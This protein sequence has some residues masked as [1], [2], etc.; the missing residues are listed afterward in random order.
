MPISPNGALG[1]RNVLARR[2]LRL[3]V[4]PGESRRA[5]SIEPRGGGR[6]RRGG[7]RRG[8]R[9]GAPAARPVL[10]GH[11][12]GD[13]SAQGRARPAASD[14]AQHRAR[15]ARPGATLLYLPYDARRRRVAADRPARRPADR[16]ARHPVGGAR[17]LRPDR[18]LD[19]RI[20]SRRDRRARRVDRLRATFRR[21]AGIIGSAQWSPTLHGRCRRSPVVTAIGPG[22]VVSPALLEMAVGDSTIRTGRLP[23]S[24]L[25]REWRE[26]GVLR[27]ARRTT[28][29]I[30]NRWRPRLRRGANARMPLPSGEDVVAWTCP[31]RLRI[32]DAGR[33]RGSRSDHP[34]RQL[35]GHR[36]HAGPVQP[37]DLAADQRG[38]DPDAADAESA[39]GAARRRSDSIRRGCSASVTTGRASWRRSSRSRPAFS[40]AATARSRG[41]NTR[42]R[43]SAAGL[44]RSATTRTTSRSSSA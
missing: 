14:A 19:R 38:A 30:A 26:S 10:G 3:G 5:R 37:P 36:Q 22:T 32:D 4:H 11:R 29:W 17:R 2:Q 40:T 24:P 41:S 25:A 34:A 20:V 15:P 13:L 18:G 8:A 7:R 27:L 21:R 42:N 12:A 35:Q 28:R 43:R 39:V 6:G 44:R 23:T 33:S 1:G 31:A 16:R 9:S